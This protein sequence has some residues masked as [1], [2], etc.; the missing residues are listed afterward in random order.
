[1]S[2]EVKVR[3]TNIVW[4]I[5]DKDNADEICKKLPKQVTHVFDLPKIDLSEDVTNW[6][7]STYGRCVISCNVEIL[8]G[9]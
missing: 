2:N 6:L 7:S 1:M 5:D 9:K 4:D 8:H 3:M